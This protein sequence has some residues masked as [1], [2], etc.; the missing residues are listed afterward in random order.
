MFCTILIYF[1]FDCISC[2]LNVFGLFRYWDYAAS[3]ELAILSNNE[4]RSRISLSRVIMFMQEPF[5]AE[6][7]LRKLELIRNARLAR[8]DLN[9]WVTTIEETLKET[10]RRL[11]SGQSPML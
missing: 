8:H 3:L 4:E 6:T 9:T 5:Q 2:T 10:L 7:T 1:L 11:S